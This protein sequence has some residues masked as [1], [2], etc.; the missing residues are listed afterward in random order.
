VAKA[1]GEVKSPGKKLHSHEL[2]DS[3]GVKKV[4]L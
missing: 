2:R 1:V 4:K 3:L